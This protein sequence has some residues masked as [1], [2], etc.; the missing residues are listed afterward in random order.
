MRTDQ[1]LLRLEDQSERARLWAALPP[2]S[3]T[4]VARVYARLCIRA[5]KIVTSG[6]EQ[7]GRNEPCML[8]R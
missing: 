2:K 7:Q 3:R 8:K 4:S 6:V 5:A 1:L